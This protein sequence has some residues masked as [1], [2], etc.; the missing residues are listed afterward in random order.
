MNKK[1]YIE[2]EVVKLTQTWGSILLLVGASIILALSFLDFIVTPENFSRFFI[3][4]LISALLYIPLLFLHIFN[5]KYKNKSLQ[6][7]IFLAAPIIAIIM[8]EV[9]ILFFG[10]H[11][12]PYYAGMIIVFAFI[13]GFLPLSTML[14]FTLTAATLLTYIIPILLFDT[15]TNHRIFVNNIFFLFAIACVG[16]VWRSATRSLLIRKLSLEYDLSQE[17]E[18]LRK[19]STDLEDIVA[20]RTKDLQISEQRYR[21]LFDSANDGIV[22]FDEQGLVFDVNREF[23]EM[24]G[25]DKG[26]LIGVDMKKLELM[27][28]HAER[29]ERMKRILSGESLVFEAEHYKEN[30]DRLIVEVSSKAI[31]IRGKIYVQSF[32]KDITDKKRL[33]AQ[34][35]QSQKM[36]SIGVLAGGIAHD[37][38]NYLLVILGHA[39]LLGVN[40]Q[41]DATSRNGIKIIESSARKAGQIVSKLL[42]F[43][44]QGKF[45]ALP[46]NFSDVLKDAVELLERSVAK[47]NVVLKIET[48]NQ[49][50]VTKGDST[51]LE[52]V[53]MNLVM[54]AVDAMP[55][56]GTI[57]LSTSLVHIGRNEMRIH[58]LLSSGHYVCLKVKDTGSGIPDEIRD[59]IFD[60]FF[61]TKG[62]EKGTGLGLAIIYG[63]VKEHNGVITVTSLL[64]R[65]TTFEVYLPTIEPGFFAELN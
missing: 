61:T 31:K 10:G 16:L 43:A 22:V 58:P 38:N 34:L 49:A 28:N 55:E 52:Q 33:L 35:F 57:T 40:D 17:K 64:G 39:E 27:K 4:R 36:E 41:L 9:M 44:R 13:I 8:V 2:Q 65:G 47:K 25:F 1:E 7:L 21:E 19:Y 24:Y 63:I 48:D 14:A 20:E 45:V 46:L 62:P 59:R 6:L 60:P 11:Q 3:Y 12:S 37:F 42:S 26:A 23:C 53:I 30:G 29:N 54:N 56:G 32:F 50:L 51:Q 5:K 18:Q 15:I